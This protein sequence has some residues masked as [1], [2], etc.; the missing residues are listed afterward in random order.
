MT[1]RKIGLAALLGLMSVF[2]FA[3]PALAAGPCDTGTLI[4]W[5]ADAFAYETNYANLFSNPA[6]NLTMVGVINLFCSPLDILNPQDPTKEYTFIFM[7]LISQGTTVIPV[8]TS[9]IYDTI[10]DQGLFF[11]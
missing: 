6:S 2:T 5:D 9:T 10:Y 8:G 4:D 1:T 7:N 11:I 3:V